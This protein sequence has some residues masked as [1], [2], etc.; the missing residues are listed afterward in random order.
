MISLAAI[1]C[2]LTFSLI[3]AVARKIKAANTET[4]RKS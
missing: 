2:I 4:P 1:V 3:H